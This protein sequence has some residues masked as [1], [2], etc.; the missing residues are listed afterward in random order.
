VANVALRKGAGQRSR[1]VKLQKGV[2]VVDELGGRSQTW[3][4]FGT[5]WAAVAP[6]ADVLSE[7]Q[8]TVIYNVTMRYRADVM[9]NYLAGLQQRVVDED[10]GITL[11]V[12]AVVDSDLRHRDMVLNCAKAIAD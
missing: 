12:L 8:A 2:A 5:D 3:P 7:V 1:R 10:A 6:L 9:D 4:Q 11:K